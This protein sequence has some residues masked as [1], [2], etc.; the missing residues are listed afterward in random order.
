MHGMSNISVL[1]SATTQDDHGEKP[2]LLVQSIHSPMAGEIS[3]IPLKMDD[4]VIPYML[5]YPESLHVKVDEAIFSLQSNQ[6]QN[7][8]LKPTNSTP[9]I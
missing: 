9:S 6:A 5:K 7:T 4:T 3:G 2:V 1:A 8:V